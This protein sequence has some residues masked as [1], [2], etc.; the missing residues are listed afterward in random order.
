MGTTYVDDR[1]IENEL[2]TLVAECDKMISMWRNTANEYS[3]GNVSAAEMEDMLALATE[4]LKDK[5]HAEA[6]LGD[7]V[8]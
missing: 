6:Q 1:A 3:M 5:K 8:L 7:L 2:T 4:A